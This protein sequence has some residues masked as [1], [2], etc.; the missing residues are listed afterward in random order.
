MNIDNDYTLHYRLCQVLWQMIYTL[1]LKKTVQ[2]CFCQNFPLI[3]SN[4]NKFLAEIVCCI[5]ILNLTRLMSPH[6]LVRHTEVPNL[7]IMLK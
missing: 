2:N 4:F 1:C 7:D 3:S 5:Y 6:Y